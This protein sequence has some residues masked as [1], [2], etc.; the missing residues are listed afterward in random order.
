MLICFIL[1]ESR[2]CHTFCGL[3]ALLMPS[4]VWNKLMV[5]DIGRGDNTDCWTGLWFGIQALLGSVRQRWRSK[6][7]ASHFPEKGEY[8]AEVSNLWMFLVMWM[9]IIKLSVSESFVRN[10]TLK[11]DQMLYDIYFF[12]LWWWSSLLRLHFK[13]ILSHIHNN[14]KVRIGLRIDLKCS[15][16]NDRHQWYI[17]GHIYLPT[18]VSI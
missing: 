14:C 7:T 10:F 1:Q 8:V 11:S 15:L 16:C 5:V 3:P 12:T 17:T 2:I 4:K 9:F 6:E 18:A 13:S